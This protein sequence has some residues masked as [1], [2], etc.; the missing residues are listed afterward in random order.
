MDNVWNT[1]NQEQEAKKEIKRARTTIATILSVAGFV[2]LFSQL[3]PLTKSFIQGRYDEIR[4]NI[5]AKPIPDSQREYILGAFA[6]YDP[7][8]SYF[9]NLSSKAQELNSDGQYTY[10]LE[11]KQSKKIL[12]DTKYSKNMSLSIPNLKI[13]KM[14]VSSNVESY[15]EKVYN[16]KLKSG[17]AH[18]KGTPLPGDGGNALIYGH[19]A[20][21]SFFNSHQNLPETIFSKLEKI[22]IG[23]DVIVFKDG[24]ELKYVVRKKRTVEADDFSILETQGDK[25]TLTLMTCWPIGI[26]SKRLIVLTHRYE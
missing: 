7:G 16:L 3:F 5:L 26:P 15:D 18:F 10:D 1:S 13:Q 23:D 20:V 14:N 25:E 24:K 22:D 8:Q 12:V 6:Y 9:K 19:S 4:A 2:L 11:T 21:P 17:L